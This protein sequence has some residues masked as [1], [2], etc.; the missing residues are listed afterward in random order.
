MSPDQCSALVLLSC[1]LHLLCH[2]D[3]SHQDSSVRDEG[4]QPSDWSMNVSIGFSLVSNPPSER[5]LDVID[6][7]DGESGQPGSLTSSR[8]KNVLYMYILKIFKVK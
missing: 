7:C 6:G 4:L 1:L 2:S 3:R 5:V 8:S